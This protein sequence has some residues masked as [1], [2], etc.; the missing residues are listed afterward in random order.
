VSDEK[1]IKDD[2]ERASEFIKAL[3]CGKIGGKQFIIYLIYYLLLAQA[4]LK[5][6]N[7]GR[8]NQEI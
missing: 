1:T 8:K 5:K 6:N 7:S 2:Q 3:D 4:I